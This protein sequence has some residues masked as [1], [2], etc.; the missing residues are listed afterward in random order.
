MNEEAATVSVSSLPAGHVLTYACGC[1]NRINPEWMVQQ[2][3]SK[4]AF[5]TSE[6]NKLGIMHHVEMGAIKDGVVQSEHY[7]AEITE[8]LA[9]LGYELPK[10]KSGNALEIG[11]GAGMY[12]KWLRSH[13][14]TYT[15]IEPDKEIAEF[16]RKEFGRKGVGID[17][18]PFDEKLILKAKF[19]VILACHVFEHLPDSPEMMRKAH[20]MLDDDGKLILIV[21]N[22]D[23]PVNPDHFWFFTPQNLRATLAKIGF[24]D[25]KMTI[26]QRVK[27]EK[28]IYCIASK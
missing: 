25:V 8:P 27:H 16:T 10:V 20:G 6:Q 3:V 13:G 9:E 23:D 21:P 7:I 26:R 28:F 1:V 5:H 11:C 22:D 24:S 19:D 17:T 12:I 15:G 2:S 4:C 14:F 18:R